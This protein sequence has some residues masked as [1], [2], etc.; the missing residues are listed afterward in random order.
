M[1]IPFEEIP[2]S[3][4][5]SI[6]T[7]HQKEAIQMSY[8]IKLALDKWDG[9][10]RTELY[11]SLAQQLKLSFYSI[12]KMAERLPRQ[13]KSPDFACPCCKEVFELKP[14]FY[15]SYH[16]LDCNPSRGRHV[17]TDDILIL[18]SRNCYDKVEGTIKELYQRRFYYIPDNEKL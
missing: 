2:E 13:I 6:L 11:D 9:S 14:I 4:V 10:R 8:H 7:G 3:F 15:W 5:S 17:K 18:C 16:N 12:R 1:L